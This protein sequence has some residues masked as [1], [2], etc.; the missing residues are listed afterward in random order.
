[1]FE[2]EEPY[3][4][5]FYQMMIAVIFI[6]FFF[7]MPAVAFLFVVLFPESDT[8]WSSF[9]RDTATPQPTIR[10]DDVEVNVAPL[11]RYWAI[12][13]LVF[14]SILTGM[15]SHALRIPCIYEKLTWAGQVKKARRI[16]YISVFFMLLF[17]TLTFSLRWEHNFQVCAGDLIPDGYY[18]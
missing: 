2:D 17:N 15:Y 7:T 4:Y 11:Y 18:S 5:N 16:I 8:C 9:S 12:T 6:I 14:N 1:M 13:G 10:D 3:I